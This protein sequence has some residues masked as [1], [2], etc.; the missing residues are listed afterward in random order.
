MSENDKLRVALDMLN[1]Q[2][3]L[4]DDCQYSTLSTKL[5]RQFVAEMRE[6]LAASKP[7]NA[8]SIDTCDL[9]HKFAKL[10]DHPKK[11]GVARCPHC[12]ATGLD[13]ERAASKPEPQSTMV[14]KQSTKPDQSEYDRGW[15]DGYKHGAWAGKPELQ[16]Y[17]PVDAPGDRI[18]QNA[19]EL[20]D[21]LGIKPEPQAQAAEPL[22]VQWHDHPDVVGGIRWSEL[23]MKWIEARDKQWREA[24]AQ[25]DAALDACKKDADR[26]RMLPAFLE[27][28]QIDYVGL[29][30]VID[31]AI[32]KVQ[33]ARK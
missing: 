24:I 3:D 2:C 25:R 13:S 17:E 32:T 12:M 19:S 28:F 31:T 4:S 33:E 26:W 15:K 20:F 21:A 14:D 7:H 5:V 22:P 29:K 23:E 30:Q 16:S 9:G 8:P 1:E 10:A 18:Y 27:E 11:D 6:A